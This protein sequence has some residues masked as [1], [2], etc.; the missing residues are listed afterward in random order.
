M[1]TIG[2]N[3]NAAALGALVDGMRRIKDQLATLQ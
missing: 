2:V 1:E 3:L